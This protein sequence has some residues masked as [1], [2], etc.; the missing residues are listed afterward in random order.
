MPEGEKGENKTGRIFS[1]IQYFLP[2][3]IILPPTSCNILLYLEIEETIES[4]TS[5][6]LLNI[7]ISIDLNGH[8]IILVYGKRHDYNF[9]IS[10]SPFF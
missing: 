6:S 7:L 10:N 8:L 1:C 2:I 3:I 4:Q 9:H 5:A